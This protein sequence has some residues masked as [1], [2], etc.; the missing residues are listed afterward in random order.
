M[1][2]AD[3]EIYKNLVLGMK[4]EEKQFLTMM[5]P[6][7]YMIEELKRRDIVL[8]SSLGKVCEILQSAT[9]GMTIDQMQSMIFDIR[10]ALKGA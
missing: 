10:S 2:N 3:K 9:E 1:T 6:S 4:E 5:I 7:E 8:N